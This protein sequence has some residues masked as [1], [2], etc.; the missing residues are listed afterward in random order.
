MLIGNHHA[1]FIEGEKD[2]VLKEIEKFLEKQDFDT[3]ANPD[4]LVLEYENLS[5]ED[6]RNLR[7]MHTG[8]AVQKD[9]KRVS[10]ITF[11]SATI[12]AQNA[13]LKMFE[14]PNPTSRFF[15][16]APS[17][18]ILIPTLKSR[19]EIQRPSVNL[20]N[21]RSAGKENKSEIGELELEIEATPEKFLSMSFGERTKAIKK[22]LDK[23]SKE[24]ISKSDIFNF[25][26]T[27]SE[28][29][30]AK[31]VSG[32]EKKEKFAH[33]LKTLSYI[34]DRSSSVKMLLEHLVLVL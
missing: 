21:R 6:A 17:L 25:L 22:I 1:Y 20:V 13:L 11:G 26:Q 4:Y 28:E 32:E 7:E 3:K 34:N 33:I 27:L 8:A 19:F 5:V 29:I 31:V 2:S 18:N 24:K 16:I 23:Y 10:V 30:R 12:E 15:I 14:E 9:G